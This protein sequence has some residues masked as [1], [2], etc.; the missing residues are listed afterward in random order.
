MATPA[1]NRL[2]FID[3]LRG[4]ALI[5][6]IEVHVFNALI[7]PAFKTTSWFHYLNFING[8]VAPSFTFISGFVFIIASQRKLESFRT[9]GPAFWKQIGRIGLVWGIGYF[10]HLPFFSFHRMITETTEEGWLL[11][12]QV[13][14]LQ[15]IAFGLFVLFLSRLLIRNNRTYRMFLLTGGLFVVAAT[16]FVYDYDFLNWI[17]A[18]IAAYINNRHY[19]LFPVFPWLAFMLFGGYFASGYNDAR[20]QKKEKEFIVRFTLI[21]VFL[22]AVCLM[23]LEL[24][25]LIHSF[26]INFT[27]NPLF[28]LERLAIVMVLLAACWFYADIRKTGKSVVLDVGRESLM[29]YTAHLLVIYGRFWNDRS[30]DFYYGGTF[31]VLEC[32]TGTLALI[33]TMIGAAIVWGW[34]KKDHGPLARVMFIMFMATVISVFLTRQM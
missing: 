20:E 2:A 31:G 25:T 34:L 7:L 26:S 33:G 24:Q 29:V 10:L 32:I 23:G 30:P 16:V 3:L 22:L 28:F 17:P 5:V 11:F 27:A 13:D 19:S 4:W 12:Y 8:L 9:Y 21:G 1:K 14:I 15:C 6:M 18:P